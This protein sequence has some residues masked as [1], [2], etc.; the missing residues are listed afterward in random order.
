MISCYLIARE[1]VKYLF[2]RL[3]GKASFDQRVITTEHCGRIIDPHFFQFEHRTGACVFGR[4]RT[5][6]DNL[7]VARQFPGAVP[8]LAEGNVQCALN[9]AGLVGIG[10]THVNQHSF[11]LF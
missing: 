5:I 6:R 7:L 3:R 2:A 1:F 10:A 11:V 4:S 9:M 8:N